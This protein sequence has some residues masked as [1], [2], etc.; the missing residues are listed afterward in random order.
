[1]VQVVCPRCAWPQDYAGDNFTIV[2]KRCKK[3]FRNTH[4]ETEMTRRRR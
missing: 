1:M 4:R 3:P 2:C